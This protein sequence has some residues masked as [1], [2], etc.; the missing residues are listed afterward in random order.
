MVDKQLEMAGRISKMMRAKGFTQSSLAKLLGVSQPTI[1]RLI[2]GEVD[3]PTTLSLIADALEVSES[4]LRYGDESNVSR[5]NSSVNTWDNRTEIPKGVVPIPFFKDFSLSAGRGA[6]NSDITHDGSVLWFAKSFLS[7]KQACP[8]KVFSI[9]VQGDSMEP[10]YAE[11][12]IAVIDSTNFIEQSL[13]DS[14]SPEERSV[15]TTS[16]VID[17]KVYAISNKGEEYIKRLRRLSP[18]KILISSD[19][20]MYPPI[21]ANAED[22]WIIGV[23]IGY[24]FEE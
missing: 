23:L 18:G 20:K 3:N 24:Q 14:L 12:G 17:G 4:W 7:R 22:I 5:I 16:R 13:Y 19:N 11:G 1:S 21:E 6:L 15:E 2:K 9:C 8:E 10:R